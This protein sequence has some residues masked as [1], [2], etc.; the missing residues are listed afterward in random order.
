MNERMARVRARFLELTESRT[1]DER[2]RQ[3]LME[4]LERWFLLGRENSRAL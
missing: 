1:G 4:V 2:V 3:Q